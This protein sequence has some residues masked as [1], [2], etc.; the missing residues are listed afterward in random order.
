M[1]SHEENLP[2]IGHISRDM[3]LCT[4]VKV[5]LSAGYRWTQSLVLQSAYKKN[6]NV[7]CSCYLNKWFTNAV[8]YDIP[9]TNTFIFLLL[10]VKRPFNW[11]STCFLRFYIR[12]YVTCEHVPTTPRSKCLKLG[13]LHWHPWIWK[14]DRKT[15]ADAV[16]K[17]FLMC[18]ERVSG[19]VWFGLMR[20][21]YCSEPDGKQRGRALFELFALWFWWVCR[22][23]FIICWFK[24]HT[25]LYVFNF[26][27]VFAHKWL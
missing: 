8:I 10:I 5:I 15:L 9:T 23:L 2:H 25:V 4:R 26:W 19:E 12:E 6:Y 21:N 11:F 1:L 16:H 14:K 22:N 13:A 18:K 27:W 24:V 3:K 20:N 17:L 7:Y